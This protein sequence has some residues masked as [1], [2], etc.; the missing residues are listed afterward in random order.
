LFIAVLSGAGGAWAQAPSAAE[1]PAPPQGI[2]EVVI[3][4]QRRSESAGRAA[5]PVSVLAPDDLRAAGVVK[6]Q[7]LGDLVPAL[8]VANTAAPIPIYYLRGAG[9]FTGNALT[10]SAVA[11]NVGGVFIGRPHATAGFFY[12]L[13]RIEVLKGPQG[14]LY[15]RNATGGAINVV[16]RNPQIG[17]WDGEANA[18]YGNEDYLRVDGAVNVPFGEKAALRT[19]LFHVS[20]D[21]CMDDGMDDQ[22]DTAGRVSLLMDPTDQLSIQLTADYFDQGAAG[23]GSM[24]V[25]LDPDNRFGISSPE[26]DAFLAT[27]TNFLVRRGFNPIDRNQYLDNQ[28]WGLS[29][30]VDWYTDAGTVTVIPAYRE[31]HLDTISTGTGVLVTTLED[32]RQTSLEARLASDLDG[33]FDYIAGV[34]WFDETNDMPLFVPNTQ[35]SLAVQEY[36]T[37]VESAAAFARLT[38]ELTESMRGTLGARYTHEDKFFE[39]SFQSSV[40]SCPP[41]DLDGCPDAARIPTDQLTPV[42]VVPDGQV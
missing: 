32:D 11:F 8:Q 2:E 28:F 27:Q 37:G 39:G 14:T 35:Y 33:R 26:T 10:D 29:G 5:L 12:D 38:Y 3:T 21:G 23:P 15:G 1:S 36:S 22:D 6:P 34:Y 16:P 18:E 40:R 9:N 30:T 25:A 24:P 19:A 31:G 41:T 7:E 13:E 20:H 17:E 42:V 4:A